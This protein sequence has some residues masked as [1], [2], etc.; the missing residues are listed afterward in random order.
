MD[1]TAYVCVCGGGGGNAGIGTEGEATSV[2][3]TEYRSVVSVGKFGVH[4]GVV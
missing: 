3:G 1:V 4:A 2:R